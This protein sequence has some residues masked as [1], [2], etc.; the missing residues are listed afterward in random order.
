LTEF[1]LL[2]GELVL[3][4]AVPCRRAGISQCSFCIEF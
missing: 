4:L 2:G 3:S 1:S